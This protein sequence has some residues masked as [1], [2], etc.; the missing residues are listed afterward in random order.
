MNASPV[1]SVT[2]GSAERLVPRAAPHDPLIEAETPAARARLERFIADRYASAYGARIRHFL[3]RLYALED[4]K[5]ELLA[6]F[7]LRDASSEGL[8]LEAYLDQPI[9]QL[10]GERCDLDV[11]RH[12]IVEIGNLAGRKKGALRMLIGQLGLLLQ[13]MGYRW[14]VFT[15]NP[16]LVNGFSRLGID[17]LELAPA[18]I[19][20]L[21]EDSRADWGRYYEGGPMVVCADITAGRA[22]LAA[23]PELLRQALPPTVSGEDA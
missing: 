5:G 7:G 21:P 17:V 10:I 16:Q 4:D 3:P 9:E 20:R 6:A 13:N 12:E 14:L 1:L 18:R 19:E 8:F 11:S 22:H 2:A 15:G 23:H